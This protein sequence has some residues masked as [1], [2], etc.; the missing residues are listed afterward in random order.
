M[1]DL[2]ASVFLVHMLVAHPGGAK[3][4]PACPVVRGAGVRPAS[5]QAVSAP[6][7]VGDDSRLGAE[8]GRAHV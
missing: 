3:P 8:I 5:G 1:P 2:I 6:C 4:Q 7:A